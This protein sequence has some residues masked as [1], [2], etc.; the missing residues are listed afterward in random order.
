M[1]TGWNEDQKDVGSTSLVGGGK[2]GSRTDR[3]FAS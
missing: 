1:A 3:D 2:I